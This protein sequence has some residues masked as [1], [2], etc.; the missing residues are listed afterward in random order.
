[1]PPTDR[2]ELAIDSVDTVAALVYALRV[3]QELHRTQ[4]Y[5]K[6]VMLHPDIVRGREG[7]GVTIL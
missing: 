6:P 4:A 5:L 7:P 3:T 1:V 2:D